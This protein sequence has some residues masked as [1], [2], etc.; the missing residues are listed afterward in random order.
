MGDADPDYAD[1]Q[2]EAD[3]V[4]ATMPA[5][6]GTVAMLAGGGHYLQAQLPGEVTRLI[7]SFVRDRVLS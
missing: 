4:V 7:T 5:G 6:L 3:E 2:A 1:P